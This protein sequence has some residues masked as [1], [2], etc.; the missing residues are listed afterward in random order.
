[1]AQNRRHKRQRLP[2]LPQDQRSL[3]PG[4]GEIW[5]EKH[6]NEASGDESQ[7]DTADH[8]KV[9]SRHR[10]SKKKPVQSHHVE[11]TRAQGIP[12][13]TGSC[14]WSD[15]SVHCLLYRYHVHHFPECLCV[16][17]GCERHRERRGGCVESFERS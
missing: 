15:G 12:Q 3:C 7:E 8:E 14:I 16:S 9:W 1:M 17:L 10:R 11:T 4:Q 6:Q 2:R 13:H 5:L